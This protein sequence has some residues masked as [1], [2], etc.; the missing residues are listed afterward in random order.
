MA[1][2]AGLDH[3]PRQG[4]W[5]CSHQKAQLGGIHLLLSFSTWSSVP[6]SYPQKLLY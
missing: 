5:D 2:L 3:S 6:E 1:F 4:S